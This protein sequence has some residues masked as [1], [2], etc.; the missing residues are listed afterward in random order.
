MRTAREMPPTKPASDEFEDRM[1][2]ALVAIENNYR[3]ETS[4]WGSRF[5][6]ERLEVVQAR[7]LIAQTRA[8]VAAEIR[9][10]VPLWAEVVDRPAAYER[11]ARIAEGSWP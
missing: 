1:A 11:A 8:A 5:E 9:A 7:H 6:G 10:Q 2:W 3:R 4:G